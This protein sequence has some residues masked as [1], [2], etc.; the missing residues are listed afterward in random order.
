MKIECL[1]LLVFVGVLLFDVARKD[2]AVAELT[3]ILAASNKMI[4]EE[5]IRVQRQTESLKTSN[6][7]LD[8]LREWIANDSTWE[9]LYKSNLTHFD[10]VLTAAEKIREQ[11]DEAIKALVEC[12]GKKLPEE[13]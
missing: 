4:Q 10:Q 9:G 5:T 12:E 6:L 11:R 8:R 1:I 2:R 7:A 3:A 13:L